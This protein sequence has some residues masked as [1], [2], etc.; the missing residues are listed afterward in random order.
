MKNDK[1]STNSCQTNTHSST[2]THSFLIEL[3][4]IKSSGQQVFNFTLKTNVNK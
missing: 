2:P 4:A 3:Y 1:E